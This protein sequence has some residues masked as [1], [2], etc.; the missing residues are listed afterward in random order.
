[1]Y[2]LRNIVR[3]KEK[4]SEACFLVVAEGNSAGEFWT[5]HGRS[6]GTQKVI[7]TGQ[8]RGANT[9]KYANGASRLE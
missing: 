7:V 6:M 3:I 1:L 4:Q 2:F 8:K 9:N 5:K